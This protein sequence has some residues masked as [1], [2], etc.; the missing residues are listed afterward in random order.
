MLSRGHSADERVE[1]KV[2]RRV[3]VKEGVGLQGGSGYK[4]V[5]KSSRRMPRCRLWR[6]C[7]ETAA[8]VGRIKPRVGARV[9]ETDRQQ[10]RRGQAGRKGGG[11]GEGPRR[12][13]GEP[14]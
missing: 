1:R 3:D 13:G 12:G 8:P 14:L 9:E 2:G 11:K 6:R 10:Q 4:W 5:R 7:R